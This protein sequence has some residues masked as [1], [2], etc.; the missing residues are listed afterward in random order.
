MED[1]QTQNRQAEEVVEERKKERMKDRMKWGNETNTE[2]R[3]K[4]NNG[5][6]TEK[7]I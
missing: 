5:V 3:M 1:L 4:N 2:K 6:I 7:Q